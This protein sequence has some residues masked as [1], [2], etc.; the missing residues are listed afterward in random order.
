MERGVRGIKLEF[1]QHPDGRRTSL[2]AYH[3][4]IERLTACQIRP[5]LAHTPSCRQIKRQAAVEK[6]IEEVRA[7]L[8][9]KEGGK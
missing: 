5:P 1:E 3:R 9:K 6:E 8:R 7:S 4:F 2:E